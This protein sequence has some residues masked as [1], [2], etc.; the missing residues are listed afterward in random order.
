MYANV[1]P[2]L[3]V[4]EKTHDEHYTAKKTEKNPDGGSYPAYLSGK[5]SD[6]ASGKTGSG[7]EIQLTSWYGDKSLHIRHQRIEEDWLLEPGYRSM[8]GYSAKVAC[9]KKLDVWPSRRK[10][11]GGSE[12]FA[13]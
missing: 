1:M 4:L 13:D 12:A 6:E 9:G 11:K 10:K 3:S 5:S 2:P 7:K 8:P